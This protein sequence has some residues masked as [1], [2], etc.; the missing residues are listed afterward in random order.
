MAVTVRQHFDRHTEVTS[1]LPNVVPA[2]ISH[3][4]AVWRSVCGMTSG[5]SFAS[6]TAWAKA[7][8][9]RLIGPKSH[10]TAN[11]CRSASTAVGARADGPE[12][13]LAAAASSFHACLQAVGRTRHVL[14]RSNHGLALVKS[15]ATHRAGARSGVKRHQD[16]SRNMLARASIGI[17]AFLLLAVPPR[18]PD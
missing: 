13:A 16:K 4:A 8:E 18:C 9:I 15:R 7:F 11:R 5:P 10:S 1:G 12:A 3:V 2:C 17:D 14:G 6:A